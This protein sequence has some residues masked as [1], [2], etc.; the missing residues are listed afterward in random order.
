[1]DI[2]KNRS[3]NMSKRIGKIVYRPPERCYA[4]VEIEETP[5]GYKIFRVGHREAFTVIPFSAVSQIEFK[6][7]DKQRHNRGDKQ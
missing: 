1:L 7:D 6:S 3:V 5:H 2:E 4:N